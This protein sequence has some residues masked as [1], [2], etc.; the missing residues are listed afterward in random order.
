MQTV[1]EIQEAVSI[2]PKDEEKKFRD[3]FIEF[4]NL[5]WDNEI[6]DDQDSEKFRRLIDEALFDY[7]SGNVKSL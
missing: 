7:K 2:L 4:D 1:L 6:S 3:W 5:K